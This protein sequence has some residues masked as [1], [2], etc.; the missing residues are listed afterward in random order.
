MSVGPW[1]SAAYPGDCSW[2]DRIEEG[3]EIRADGEGEYEHRECAELH[4]VGLEDDPSEP[5]VTIDDLFGR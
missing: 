3:D 1:F 4:G 2:G 5:D